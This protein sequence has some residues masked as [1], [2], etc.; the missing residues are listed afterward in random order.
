MSN[1]MFLIIHSFIY[2]F[3]AVSLFFIPNLLWPLYGVEVNDKYA[4]FLSQHNSIFLGGMAVLGFLFRDVQENS[5]TA[6]KLFTGF[7]WTSVFG[8]MITL[9][10][11]FIGVFY[12]FGWSDPLFFAL[13]TFMCFLQIKRNQGGP[14]IEI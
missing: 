10:A 13:L 1:K 6:Q 2:A 9:Y 4:Y 5:K 14:Q 7:L 8:C 3:F 12:G 11:C